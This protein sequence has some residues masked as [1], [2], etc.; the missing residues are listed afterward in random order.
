MEKLTIGFLPVGDVKTEDMKRDIDAAIKTLKGR[1]LEIVSRP[2]SSNLQELLAYAK[3]L[4]A[5]RLD[6]LV[7]FCVHGSQAFNLVRVAEGTRLPVVIWALPVRYSLPASASAVG[8]LREKGLGV[9]LL[10]G[11][12]DSGST[13]DELLWVT[14]VLHAVRRLREAKIGKIGGLQGGAYV[15]GNFN[16]EAL[17]ERFGVEVVD[18][19]VREVMDAFEEVGEEQ[20][21]GALKE[22]RRRF[23][24]IEAGEQDLRRAT[25]LSLALKRL[26]ERYGLSALALDLYEEVGQIFRTSS[27]L[28]FCEDLIMQYEGDVI[29]LIATLL[30]KYLADKPVYLTDIFSIDL[31]KSL[32]TVLHAS[33]PASLA[34]DDSKVHIGTDTPP[35][36]FGDY[37]IVTCKPEIPPGPVTIFRLFGR[38]KKIFLIWLIIFWKNL[39]RRIKRSSSS[40]QN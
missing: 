6:A 15:S 29:S 32:L 35:L 30:V 28:T 39:I 9:K 2:A 27:F 37:T 22:W 7:L 19:R 20:V 13:T 21:E 17:H 40:A 1:Q 25:R 8:N 12:A 14:K 34:Q 38:G 18:I 36:G 24:H 31:E 16:K 26:F 11:A 10:Y 3:E 4:E 33:A 23:Q 5:A